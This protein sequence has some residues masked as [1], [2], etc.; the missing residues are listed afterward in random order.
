MS[1]FLRVTLWIC[2]VTGFLIPLPGYSQI[3]TGVPSLLDGMT[4]ENV[5]EAARSNGFPDAQYPFFSPPNGCGSGSTYHLTPNGSPNADFR[6]ACINHDTCY[7]TGGTK[8]ECDN[9]FLTQMS[10]IC[11]SS[12]TSSAGRTLCNRFASSF[13]NAV[14]SSLGLRAFNN[15][16]GEQTKYTNWLNDYI[17]GWHRIPQV[18]SSCE[19][20]QYGRFCGT[21]TWNGQYFEAAWGNGAI[22]KLT[23][24]QFD[25]N[26]VILIRRD[27]SGISS[28]FWA[29][30]EGTPSD[31]SVEDGAVVGRWHWNTGRV[32]TQNWTWTANW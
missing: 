2:P 13:Y 15:A 3:P 4:E 26:R 31:N 29:R 25:E 10:N 18:V 17:E 19:T 23:V 6:P 7:M 1:T 14:D 20:S 30:Y 11:I 32:H 9:T 8:E 24:I 22:G 21:W 28:G 12:I 5:N 16:R 27:D